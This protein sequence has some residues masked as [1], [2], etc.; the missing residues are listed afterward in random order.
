M[1]YHFTYLVS[2]FLLL[3]AGIGAAAQDDIP[4]WFFEP[5]E[6]ECVGV[7]AP[8]PGHPKLCRNMALASALFDAFVV[9]SC[10]SLQAGLSL[11]G[12]LSPDSNCNIPSNQD[13]RAII[14]TLVKEDKN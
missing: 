12:D 9:S 10:D 2:F 13:L 1:K 6:G 4:D 3:F 11:H 8:M 5:E 7:S 14:H